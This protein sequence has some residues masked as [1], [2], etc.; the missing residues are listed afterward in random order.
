MICANSCL[1]QTND[2]WYR[3]AWG[4]LKLV[5]GQKQTNTEQKVRLQLYRY[6]ELNL[7]KGYFSIPFFSSQTQEPA[8]G[9]WTAPHVWRCWQYLTERGK[10]KEHQYPATLYVCVKARPMLTSREVFMRPVYPTDVERGKLTYEQL[11][12]TYTSKAKKFDD[13]RR[14]STINTLANVG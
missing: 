3:F 1:R 13:L 2:G 7:G 9:H 10:L 8:P 6:P 11:M 14:R 4:F 12:D 5:G